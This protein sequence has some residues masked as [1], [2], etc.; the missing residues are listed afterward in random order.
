METIE[1]PDMVDE[2][3]LDFLDELRDSGAVNMFGARENLREEFGVDRYE[4]SIILEYWMK[5]FS[6]RHPN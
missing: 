4:S 3:H 2:G 6:E 5:S 1:R